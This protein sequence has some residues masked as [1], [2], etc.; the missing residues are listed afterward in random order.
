MKVIF[1]EEALDDLQSVFAWIAEHNPR[2]AQELVARIFD[3]TE[4]L[5]TLAWQTW[6]VQAWILVRAS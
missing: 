3:R 1:D 4:L 2:A 5:A 6:G